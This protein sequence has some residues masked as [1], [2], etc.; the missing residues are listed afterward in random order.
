[1]RTSPVIPA[2]V[3][4]ATL[5]LVH[6]CT[7]P[8][9]G[10]SLD[11]VGGA[12]ST[13]AISA[14][15]T[16]TTTAGTATTTSVTASST[17]TG[18]VDCTTRMD[19][20]PDGKCATHE[21]T[22]GKCVQAPINEGGTIPDASHNCVKTVCVGGA[23][24]IVNDDDDLDDDADPCTVDGCGNGNPTHV[25]G[26]DGNTC[27]PPGQHCFGGKCL[28]CGDPLQCPQGADPCTFATCNGGLCGLMQQDDGTVCAGSGACK[29]AGMCAGGVCAQKNK[30]DGATC[31]IVGKCTSGD[32]CFLAVCENGTV[33][34]GLGQY[35]N[36]GQHCKP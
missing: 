16:S 17:S 20:A 26:N 10:R 31:S 5:A 27:G 7:L 4:A 12:A 2:L 24:T 25:A 30:N 29:D 34:C 33:C 14:G 19:C 15:G 35:C 3:A 18:V 6:G 23:L 11:G 22:A 32:C 36:A 9:A 21:C 8:L 28:E 13:S 1:M